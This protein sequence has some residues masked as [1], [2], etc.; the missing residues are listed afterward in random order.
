MCPLTFDE[1]RQYR[2]LILMNNYSDVFAL[3][4]CCHMP[5]KTLDYRTLLTNVFLR[6]KSLYAMRPK[7]KA[8]PWLSW[9]FN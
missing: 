2:S 3:Y 9:C 1:R 6:R 7:P 5:L 8:S 4:G